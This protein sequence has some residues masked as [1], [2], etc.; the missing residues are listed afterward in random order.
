MI[1]RPK[2]YKNIFIFYTHYANL[3]GE[4]E[5]NRVPR[6]DINNFDHQHITNVI[7]EAVNSYQEYNSTDETELINLIHDNVKEVTSSTF[8]ETKVQTSKNTL[9]TEDHEFVNHLIK[10]P[11]LRLSPIPIS[12]QVIYDNAVQELHIKQL[13]Q[14]QQQ[15][16]EN[17]SK[18]I[19]SCDS[20]TNDEE[21]EK[22][23][24]VS[25]RKHLQQYEDLHRQF[26]QE[27]EKEE[28]LHKKREIAKL[29]AL[30]HNN[31]K[32]TDTIINHKNNSGNEISDKS[33]EV[34]QTEVQNEDET[35]YIKVPVKD[36]ITN[37][38][39]QSQQ[40]PPSAPPPLLTEKNNLENS[41]REIATDVTEK[42]NKGKKIRNI[43]IKNKCF[44][45]YQISYP[46]FICVLN[47][48]YY[49]CIYN[50]KILYPL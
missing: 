28:L 47:S 5:N 6:N 50:E 1:K 19:K 34:Q 2:L 44:S 46:I 38:E 12:T 15:Q 35:E 25:V 26:A 18:N 29:K 20:Q 45:V 3:V 13:K 21:N 4:I 43:N 8:V 37:F 17:M 16:Q 33:N 11:E 7:E 24:K 41:E 31:N 48:K 10:S 9:S 40:T 23:E 22:L 39:Q 32:K 27:I 42:L 30:K 49:W 14:L 36:L